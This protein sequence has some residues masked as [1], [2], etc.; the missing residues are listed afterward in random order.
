MEVKCQ[1]YYLLK[2]NLFLL[3]LD[4]DDSLVFSMLRKLFV[5]PQVPL[6]DPGHSDMGMATSTFH[7]GRKS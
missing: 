3:E 2:S 4:H 1:N 6:L 5:L 7:F